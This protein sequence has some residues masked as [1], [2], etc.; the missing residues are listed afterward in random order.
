MSQ[1]L[2]KEIKIF[3]EK[4]HQLNRDTTWMFSNGKRVYFLDYNDPDDPCRVHKIEGYVQ[5]N[6]NNCKNIVGNEI[7]ILLL[8]SLCSP[9][10]NLSSYNVLLSRDEYVMNNI[11]LF[12]IDKKD[13]WSFMTK[14]LLRNE[15]YN[16]KRLIIIND[17]LT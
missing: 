10:V 14:R 3:A 11:G 5:F 12:E 15:E 6:Y 16:K 8:W 9:A 17:K 1:L 2:Q 13:C 4:F 7:I